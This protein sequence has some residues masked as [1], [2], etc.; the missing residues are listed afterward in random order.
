M[1]LP[2][3]IRII[4]KV[5]FERLRRFSGEKPKTEKVM[6]KISFFLFR[7]AR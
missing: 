6:R 2:F 4:C 1:S 3:E 7:K 5:S